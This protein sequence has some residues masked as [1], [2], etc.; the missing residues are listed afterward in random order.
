MA[1][2]TQYQLHLKGY[3][4]GYDFDADYV[5]Y[6]FAK[7]AGKE[8]N[9]LIDSQKLIS[10]NKSDVDYFFETLPKQNTSLTSSH[11]K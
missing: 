2:D 5:D 3:V 10:N 4:G 11:N 1:K 7:N 6:I 8:V 9:V